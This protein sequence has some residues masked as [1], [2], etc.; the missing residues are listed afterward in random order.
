MRS[1]TKNGMVVSVLIAVAI[2]TTSLVV[3]TTGGAAEK[4]RP[5]GS[6][7]VT[8]LMRAVDASDALPAEVSGMPASSWIAA[9]SAARRIA[10]DPSYR[11]WVA[12][13]RGGFICLIVQVV[14]EAGTGITCAPRET[15]KSEPIYMSSINP[16]GGVDVVGIVDDAV[17]SV[18]SSG[19]SAVVKSN[20]FILKNMAGTSLAMT[21]SGISR[22]VE[23]GS[24]R[25]KAPH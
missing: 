10:T 15:L 5:V 18:S 16:G 25:P 13:G 11:A 21:G 12:P 22:S 4:P 2:A 6:G 9:S 1:R 8:A 23:L 19:N 17:K 3:A 24:L 14:A 7:S 20:A